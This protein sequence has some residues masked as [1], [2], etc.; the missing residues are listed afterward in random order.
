MP[1]NTV[2]GTTGFK[3]S[4]YTDSPEN[5]MVRQRLRAC[6]GLQRERGC[7]P[8]VHDPRVHR[9]SLGMTWT[10]P[11]LPLR[12]AVQEIHFLDDWLLPLL[13]R[14]YTRDLME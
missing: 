14:Y 4:D 1:S 3:G 6:S 13:L 9:R 10:D 12:E 7:V 5:R 8:K 11:P 2:T